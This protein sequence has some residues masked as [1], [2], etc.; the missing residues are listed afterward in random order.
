MLHRV[1]LVHLGLVHE[2][3]GDDEEQRRE[4][5]EH[6]RAAPHDAETLAGLAEDPD[7]YEGYEPRNRESHV[8]DEVRRPHEQALL[9]ALLNRRVLGRLGSRS[10]ATGV[11][12]ANA[13]AEE[14]A[15]SDEAV[16][17][18]LG[19]TR[20]GSTENETDNDDR[21]EVS[22]RCCQVRTEVRNM[23]GLRPILSEM[24]PKERIP[25]ITEV[26][27]RAGN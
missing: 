22:G 24:T 8:D 12:A 20:G 9:A 14:E 11:L 1:L 2:Q 3:A 16:D 13:D 15:K 23:P 27:Y 17:H 19:R 7:Q 5:A 10:R 21:L 18:D 25:R 4:G 26:S 6:E